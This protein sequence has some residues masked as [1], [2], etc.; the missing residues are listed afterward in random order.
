MA[1]IEVRLVS[2]DACKPSSIVGQNGI[3]FQMKT[4]TDIEINPGELQVVDSGMEIKIPRGYRLIMVCGPSALEKNLLINQHPEIGKFSPY[5]ESQ[6]PRLTYIVY[7]AGKSPALIRKGDPLGRFVLDRT[8]IG[9]DIQEVESFEETGTEPKFNS[10]VEI[11][12]T[13]DAYFKRLYRDDRDNCIDMFLTN[14]DGTKILED[15]EIYK[16]NDPY[17]NAKNQSLL[18][19]QFVWK[20][21]TNSIKSEVVKKFTDIRNNM[22]KKSRKD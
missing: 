15:L 3:Y 11:P 8:C 4:P 5:L 14:T 2:N 17:V 12:K 7:N 10:I 1:T 9:A 20:A 13:E 18:E 22:I 21:L 19:A 6:N 16:Q